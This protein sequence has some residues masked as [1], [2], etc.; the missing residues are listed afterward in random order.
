MVGARACR[1]LVNI[2][3]TAQNIFEIVFVSEIKNSGTHSFRE[4]LK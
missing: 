3:P 2:Y 1:S 4:T